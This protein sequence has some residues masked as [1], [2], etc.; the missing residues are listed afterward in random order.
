MN[1]PVRADRLDIADLL[2]KM[3]IYSRHDRMAARVTHTIHYSGSDPKDALPEWL[4]T[5]LGIVV[6]LLLS[7]TF[8]TC[9]GPQGESRQ[10]DRGE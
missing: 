1:R 8:V 3:E 2:A 6:W 9:Y 5:A 7:V 4:V 10:R